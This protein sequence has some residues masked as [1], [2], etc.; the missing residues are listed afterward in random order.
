MGKPRVL[1]FP[2]Y[3]A[4]EWSIRPQLEEWAD[5]PRTDFDAAV[6]STYSADA[7][8]GLSSARVGSVIAWDRFTLAD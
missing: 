6:R 1:L 5:D 2:S 4:L 7:A 8:D 3:S